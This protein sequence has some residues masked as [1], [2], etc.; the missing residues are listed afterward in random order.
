MEQLVGQI[1]V[2]AAGDFT[3]RDQ[4]GVQLRKTTC[5]PGDVVLRVD[6]EDQDAELPLHGLAQPCRRHV[7]EPEFGREPLAGTHRV[8]EP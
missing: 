5:R 7:A 8:L 1:E 6:H 3:P 4:D 2:T